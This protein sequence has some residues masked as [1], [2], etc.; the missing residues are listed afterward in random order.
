MK[1]YL[2]DAIGIVRPGLA[3][4]KAESETE[5]VQKVSDFVMAY[6]HYRIFRTRLVP[7]A[8]SDEVDYEIDMSCKLYAM[9]DFLAN[10]FADID[11]LD[12]GGLNEEPGIGGGRRIG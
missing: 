8:E 9:M 12:S 7:G 6:P 5:A 3:F 2:T 1:L 10:E 4:V 11:L